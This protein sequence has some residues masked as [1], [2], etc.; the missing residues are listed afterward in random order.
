MTVG[1]VGAGI[2]GLAV[3]HE[4][5]KRGVDVI[6][7][8]AESEPGGIMRSRRVDGHLLELGP[9]RLRYTP[10]IASLIDTLDLAGSIRWGDDGQPLF[11]YTD[12]KLRVAPL[13]PRKAVTT[14]LLSMKGK[15]RMLAEPL[16]SPPKAGETVDAFLRR[17]FGDEA[18]SR[19]LGPLYSG[20]YGTDPR[21]MLVEYSLGRALK[22]AG[23]EGSILLWVCKALIQGRNPPPIC[24]FDNGLGQLPRALYER[25]RQKVSLETAVQSIEKT[26]TGYRLEHDSGRDRVESLVLTPPAPETASLLRGVHPQTAAALDRLR[27]NRITLVFL[28]SDFTKPGIGTLVPHEEPLP[29]SGLTWNS[30]FLGRD[31]V[32][33]SYLDPVRYPELR[34]E[35]DDEIADTAAAAFE[36]ITGAAAT[37]IHVHHWD[38]GMPAYDTSWRALDSIDPPESVHLCTNYI[39]RPGIPGRL[40]HAARIAEQIAESR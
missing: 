4:L 11:V 35:T 22:T 14:D 12:G 18:A 7:F 36:M 34:D 30:S 16:A 23:I 6:A 38:P 13:S 3:V 37:P 40:K 19:F 24:T 31:S 32:F 39:E 9:Q 1:V 28:E 15:L 17:S 26:D 2:S 8:E 21:D 20:L 10:R 25:H 29:V 27:Y 5:Q 33:T